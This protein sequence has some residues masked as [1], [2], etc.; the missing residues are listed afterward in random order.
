[1]NPKWDVLWK[2]PS[3]ASLLKVFEANI[4]ARLAHKA[5]PYPGHIT[6]FSTDWQVA[7]NATKEW[8]KMTTAGLEDHII[9]GSH[10]PSSPEETGILGKENIATFVEVFR[11]ALEHAQ[12]A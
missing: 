1:M 5:S 7:K 10:H 8:R 4:V 3:K 2:D 11:S 9:P 12:N 6:K